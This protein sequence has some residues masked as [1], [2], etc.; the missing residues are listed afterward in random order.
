MAIG[1][2]GDGMGREDP[3][4]EYDMMDIREILCAKDAKGSY[5]LFLQLEQQAGEG[6]ALF[7]EYRLYLEML[8]SES[9][10]HRVRGF[11]M[12]CAG[13][14]WDTQGV[15]HGNL[16]PILAQL[17]DKKPTAVRQ[18]LAALPT[19]VKGRPELTVRVCEVVA[20]LDFSGYRDTM[21]PLLEKDRE[22]FLEEYER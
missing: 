12:L 1:K 10:Y 22:A 15:I 2:P 16:P 5:P 21:R 19:L 8:K 6:P 11:R 9:S 7:Q 3:G 4:R 18:C 20:A 14:K 13:A 17:E